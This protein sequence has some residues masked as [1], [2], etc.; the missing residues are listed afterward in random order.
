MAGKTLIGGTAYT[1]KGG[2]VKV[3][4]TNYAIKGGKTLIGGTAKTISFGRLPSAYQEVEYIESTGTQYIDT[5]A[6]PTNI[7][8]F[9]AKMAWTQL[10]GDKS[11]SVTQNSNG[12]WGVGAYGSSWQVGAI[13]SPTGSGNVGSITANKI[14]NVEYNYNG[15]LSF[16]VDGST[17]KSS[18]NKGSGTMTNLYIFAFNNSG[19]TIYQGKLK[20]YSYTLYN[21]T[22]AVRNF[23]PCYRISD[24]V[25]GLYDTVN[26]VFYTN[27]GS[28]TFAKGSNV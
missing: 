19:N 10:S 14:Y 7:Y 22:T 21:G 5:G 6:I 26:G 3:N 15:S 23:V 9:R 2:K 18:I 11:L 12:R 24:S 28:G 20:L 27:K 17:V 1:I 25:V 13:C 4:G 8:G 16:I